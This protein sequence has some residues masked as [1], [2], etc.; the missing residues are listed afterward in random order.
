MCSRQTV[1]SKGFGGK[2][3]QFSA[4]SRNNGPICTFT[5][6]I[7][8]ISHLFRTLWN[9]GS[10]SVDHFNQY[11]LLFQSYSYALDSKQVSVDRAI[12]LHSD[13]M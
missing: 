5:S 8:T 1:F 4:H 6:I 10:L 13:Y 3:F 7:H 12:Q 9:R 11:L 2:N